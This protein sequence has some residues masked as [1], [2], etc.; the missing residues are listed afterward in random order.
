MM[1][2]AAPPA[3]KV[4]AQ[5]ALEVAQGFV[6]D[7]LT[8]LMGTGT[9][10]RTGSPF[11]SVWVVPIWIAYPGH[12]QVGTIGSVAMDEA[13]GN[14]VSW[15]P[16]EEMTANAERFYSQNKDAIQSGFQAIR[17]TPAAN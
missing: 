4:S 11:G 6:A 8:D 9:P 14:I 5:Q 15:T 2:V 16:V 10:W 17:D 3:T 12:N 7:Y 1:A 13:T